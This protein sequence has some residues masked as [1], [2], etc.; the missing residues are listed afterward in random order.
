M[1]NQLWSIDNIQTTQANPTLTQVELKNQEILRK[2]VALHPGNSVL[3]I[4]SFAFID[5]AEDL[6][7]EV[8]TSSS[9]LSTFQPDIPENKADI[10]LL[11]RNMEN[12]EDVLYQ[13]LAQKKRTR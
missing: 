11:L 4:T 9:P 3:D 6:L 13:A 2:I 10:S 1:P 12:V 5:A 7:N 8:T